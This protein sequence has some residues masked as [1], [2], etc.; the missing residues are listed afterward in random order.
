MWNAVLVRRE[1]ID[2]KRRGKVEGEEELRHAPFCPHKPVSFL[3]FVTPDPIPC[4]TPIHAPPGSS[5]NPIQ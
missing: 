1:M 2:E 3:F 5:S 4:P